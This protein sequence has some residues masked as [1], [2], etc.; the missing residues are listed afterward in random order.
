LRKSLIAATIL[1]LSLTAAHARPG[2]GNPGKGHGNGGKHAAET[3]HGKDRGGGPGKHQ[4]KKDDRG[5]AWQ[6]QAKN[7]DRGGPGKNKAKH[8]DRGGPPAAREWKEARSPGKP[9]KGPKWKNDGGRDV[10]RID[11][12]RD[13]DWDEA[14]RWRDRD[15]RYIDRVVE[16]RTIRRNFVDGCPP[17]LAKKFNG[18]M[19][20]GLAKNR[21]EHRYYY[22]PDYWGYSFND[23]RRYFYRDGY[24]LRLGANDRISAFVPLLGGALAVGS[25]WPSFYEPRVSLDPYYVDYF[26]LG[27]PRSYRYADNVIYRVNPETTAIMSVAALLTG[28]QF[29]VGQPMPAGYGVYNVPFAYRDRYYDRPDALYRYSDGYVYEIDPKTML[30]ASAISLV[31]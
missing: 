25:Q 10:V 5:G 2:E 24:L 31:I 21:A 20:P 13:D 3:M 28:D 7:E 1:A 12:G 26:D 9:D 30:V 23:D 6:K 17:G 16:R 15:V 22:R 8:D 11:R 29:T 19:P 18:C 14:R 27:P 4:G